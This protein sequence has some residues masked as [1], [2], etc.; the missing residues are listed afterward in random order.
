MAL[1]LR[2]G[3]TLDQHTAR[4]LDCRCGSNRAEWDRAG[5]CREIG[6]GPAFSDGKQMRHY[7]WH[8][9]PA[10]IPPRVAIVSGFAIP[11]SSTCARRFHN[12]KRINHQS[13]DCDHL[14]RPAEEVW[15][16]NVQIGGRRPAVIHGTPAAAA[17]VGS[18]LF[19]ALA[20]F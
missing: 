6:D 3:E 16:T 4:F 18:I 9:A 8:L 11:R 1:Q 15:W 7:L 14:S 10:A 12:P 13:L 17:A 5:P 2:K 19:R 20:T